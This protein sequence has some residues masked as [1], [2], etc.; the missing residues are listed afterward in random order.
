MDPRLGALSELCTGQ[1]IESANGT[2]LSV[3]LPIIR[4][5]LYHNSIMEILASFRSR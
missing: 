3:L 5:E 1:L 2:G 4:Q